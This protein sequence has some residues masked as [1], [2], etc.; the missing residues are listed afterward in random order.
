MNET[1]QI[2]WKQSWRDYFSKEDLQ[3]F[4][5]GQLREIAREK[6]W[7]QGLVRDRLRYNHFMG[8]SKNA[9]VSLFA[10]S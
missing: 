10:P 9:R 5:H 6:D 7:D 1:R 4:P 2:E 8:T 3:R